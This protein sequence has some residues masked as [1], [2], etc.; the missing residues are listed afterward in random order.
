MW[1]PWFERKL[2]PTTLSLYTNS[3][4]WCLTFLGVSKELQHSIPFV[5]NLQPRGVIAQSK[6]IE[7]LL[8]EAPLPLRLYIMLSSDIAMRGGTVK[9]LCENDWDYENECFR[10]TTKAG[11]VVALP[12]SARLKQMI[13]M[14]HQYPVADK[15]TPYVARIGN[16]SDPRYAAQ[17]FAQRLGR[18][19]KALELPTFTTHDLRRSAARRMYDLTKDLRIVQSLLGHSNLSSTFRY[20]WPDMLNVTVDQI[21][22]IASNAEGSTKK[23]LNAQSKSQS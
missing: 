23:W 21:N 19:V 22:A 18:L 10:F 2:R 14:I 11:R 17:N 13:D 5:R 3:L 12:P 7:R 16:T 6:D 4:R 15:A 8:V 20:L 1:S 9:K